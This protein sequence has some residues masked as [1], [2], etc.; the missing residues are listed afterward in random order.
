MLSSGLLNIF[1]ALV[2]TFAATALLVSSIL[3]AIASVL[4]WRASTLLTGLK[5]ILNVESQA[6]QGWLGFLAP[7][8]PAPPPPTVAEVKG[9]L[10]RAQPELPPTKNR[11]PNREPPSAG[12][13]TDA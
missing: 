4:K 6:D 5:S 10:L 12:Q 9:A 7:V 2:L 13:P 1:I 11:N 8:L 3:E